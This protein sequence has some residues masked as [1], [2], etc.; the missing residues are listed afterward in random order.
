M[1]SVSSKCSVFKLPCTVCRIFLM[2]LYVIYGHMFSETTRRWER[3]S[4]C[5]V[6][7]CRSESVL[8]MLV[9][10][11]KRGNTTFYEWRTGAVPTV[12]ER[13]LVEDAP[14]DSISEDT[15][16]FSVDPGL[17]WLSGIVQKCQNRSNR[18][19]HVFV[20]LCLCLK[21]PSD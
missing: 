21:P 16:G 11:Q 15:V 9:F 3:S 12:I 10:A 5:H 17:M 14:P 8:P 20:F 6:V 13:Q 19:V 4:G 7:L 18:C 1:V 2:F